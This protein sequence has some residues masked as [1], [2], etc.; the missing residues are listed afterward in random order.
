MGLSV[1]TKLFIWLGASVVVA[2]ALV[3]TQRIRNR[4]LPQ[5][6]QWLGLLLST[7]GALIGIQNVYL[8]LTDSAL[9]EILKEDG[10][11]ALVI[12]GLCTLWLS[13]KEIYKLFK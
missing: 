10:S 12:G 3:I 8:A 4:P 9:Q 11:I 13:G 5:G 1:Q 2:I 6:N 7:S